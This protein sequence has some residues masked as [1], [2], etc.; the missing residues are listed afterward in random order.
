MRKFAL[1]LCLALGACSTSIQTRATGM[2]F[3][4]G[5]DYDAAF[6]SATSAAMAAG[7]TIGSADKSTGLINATRAAN[8][9]LTYSNP[10]INIMVQRGTDG[11]S[12][13]VASTV[14]GQIIDY[15][16]TRKTI[17]DYC[18]ALLKALPSATCTVQET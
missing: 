9:L 17:Q 16:T 11:V 2:G 18:D 14:G 12:I 7:F 5:A 8:A 15:G 6:Q 3:I 13:Q 4:K 1:V 10:A